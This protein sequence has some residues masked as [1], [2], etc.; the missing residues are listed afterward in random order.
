MTIKMTSVASTSISEIGYKRRTMNV[1]FHN[2]KLYEFKKVPRALFDKFSN[3][4]S[5][6]QFF[7]QEIKAG[8]PFVELA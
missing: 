6:G 5:I 4:A 1:K 8:Y 7:N 3:S 2:G